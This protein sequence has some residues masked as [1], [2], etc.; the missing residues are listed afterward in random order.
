MLEYLEFTSSEQ[1]SNCDE[2][3]YFELVLQIFFI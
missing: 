1:T 2:R 3:K